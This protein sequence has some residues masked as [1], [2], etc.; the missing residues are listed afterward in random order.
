MFKLYRKNM[1]KNTIVSP[2]GVTPE[3]EAVKNVCINYNT[4]LILTPMFKSLL[5]SYLSKNSKYIVSSEDL[6]MGFYFNYIELNLKF[7]VPLTA[8]FNT[9]D[10]LQGI[11]GIAFSTAQDCPS[12]KRGLCQLP[13]GEL[14]YAVKGE[15]QGSKKPHNYLMGMGSYYNGL[16]ASYYFS[17]FYNSLDLRT[18]FKEYCNYFNIDTLRFNLKGD[19]RGT[20]DIK[21]L[22]YIAHMGL[23]LTGYTA[24]DDLRQYLF[25]LIN[26][27]DNIILNGSN[28]MYNNHFKAVDNIQQYL[29]APH[30][31]LGGCLKNG[32]LNCY[33]LKGVVISVLIHGSGAGVTLNTEANREFICSILKYA[34]ININPEALAKSKDLYKKLKAIFK[35]EGHY[36]SV[37]EAF[38]KIDKKGNVSFK[39]QG[40]IIEYLRYIIH[41]NHLDIKAP[42]ASATKGEAIL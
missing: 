33:R 30:Q 26:N 25:D 40:A 39:S 3:A 28:I 27:H 16:L 41:I 23:N 13:D 34:N 36:K 19:F 29:T 7:K 32:C 15:R 9:N 21:S 4:Y 22:E 11:L 5:S 8:L 1:F 37:P 31:C 2:E 6:K 14:C 20:K 38:K 12:N 18:S 35:T 24:R 10:K 42:E 17:R